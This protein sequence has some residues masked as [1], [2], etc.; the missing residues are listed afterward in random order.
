MLTSHDSEECFS[1]TAKKIIENYVGELATRY[2]KKYPDK[3]A[4]GFDC[5]RNELNGYAIFYANFCEIPEIA[6]V[7]YARDFLEKK[8]L[9]DADTIISDA[10]YVA[11]PYKRHPFH[12]RLPEAKVD[13]EIGVAYGL[14]YSI[15]MKLIRGAQVGVQ[16]GY[17]RLIGFDIQSVTIFLEGAV[18][19]GDGAVDA[20]Y[21]KSIAQHS[22][23]YEF[24][25]LVHIVVARHYR[26]PV[27]N[28][29]HIL[30]ADNI[31]PVRI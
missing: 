5:G 14:D 6:I 7:I 20:L 25:A 12:I 8:I 19:C 22:F 13:V 30:L 3:C 21:D 27:G 29:R 26:L 23:G 28:H 24:E 10:N 2:D 4:F 1:D 18:I 11:K 15:E 17:L 9:C 31:L 16:R